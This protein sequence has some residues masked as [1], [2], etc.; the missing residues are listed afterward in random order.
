[1]HRIT[2][3]ALAGS[4]LLQ[5]P[6]AAAPQDDAHV[7]IFAS[8]LSGTWAFRGGDVHRGESEEVDDRYWTRVL[9]DA[10]SGRGAPTELDVAWYRTEFTWSRERREEVFLVLGRIAGAANLW[11]NGVRLDR[12][13]PESPW[14]AQRGMPHVYPVDG[15]A[16]RRGRN[17]IALRV[18]RD[19]GAATFGVVS[20]PLQVVAGAEASRLLRMRPGARNGFP[21]ANFAIAGQ[22]SPSG[23]VLSHVEVDPVMR[24]ESPWPLGWGELAV[25]E[26][27]RERELATQEFETRSMQRQWPST[28]YSFEDA[29]FPGLE[30]SGSTYAPVAFRDLWVS[31]LPVLLSDL[32]VTNRSGE[33]RVLFL[34]FRFH[35]AWDDGTGFSQQM[36]QDQSRLGFTMGVSPT[37]ALASDGDAVIDSPLP[38]LYR[39]TTR[40]SLRPGQSERVRMLLA[41]RHPNS[42]GHA[43]LPAPSTIVDVSYRN[44]SR[45]TTETE[46]VDRSL[47]T[48]GDGA[49]DRAFRWTTSAAV[50]A[51]RV[52]SDDEIAMLDGGLELVESG[53][54]AS[55]PHL[56]LFT[57]LERTMIERIAA[58]QGPNGR[59]PH[60]LGNPLAEEPVDST[61][62]AWFVLRAVR[63]RD[64]LGLERLPITLED[65]VHAAADYLAREILGDPERPSQPGLTLG[66][67]IERLAAMQACLSLYTKRRPP[68]AWRRAWSRLQAQLLTAPQEGGWWN[69][70][71]FGL[72]EARRDV[73]EG[74][75]GRGDVLLHEQSLLWAFSL[76]NRRAHLDACLAVF[77]A[78]ETPFGIPSRHI[79][80]GTT[81]EPTGPILP[82]MNY[83]DALGRI[84]NGY[85]E[86]G[87]RLLR[88]LVRADL[89]WR[90]ENLPHPALL[91]STGAAVGDGFDPRSGT[92]AAAFM[93]GVLGVSR[94]GEVLTMR[95]LAGLDEKITTLSL[96]LP[97]G[98]LTVRREQQGKLF[99]LRAATRSQQPILVHYGLRLAP[100]EAAPLLLPP[101]DSKDLSPVELDVQ[102]VH[103]DRFAIIPLS[104]QPAQAS[105]A[106]VQRR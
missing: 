17:L 41:Y 18:D 74:E 101:K 86:D 72:P 69:G 21:A 81:F 57:D 84:Q 99:A 77:K 80:H 61:A 35:K 87:I 33:D 67:R 62:T 14:T 34:R 12:L 30:L 37:L 82:Y 54:H 95:P 71:F 39:V 15:S 68:P 43:A 79:G 4:L 106:I 47:P 55:Y 16:L 48:S 97:L 22:V 91:P 25:Y 2:L 44:W 19:P 58:A 11:L 27:L 8:S 31:D 52:T 90:D 45:L 23:Q 50:R 20:G 1:M 5:C 29:R 65:P 66:S 85:A 104:L 88:S 103:D 105:E 3:I 7:A 9:P 36:V 24:G 53:F 51:T 76:L 10:R 63:L 78:V 40:L 96:V 13:V 94:R 102:R 100:D 98:G 93:G 46:R 64:W 60:A 49:F 73:G 38:N 89:G 83:L 28:A 70:S 42:I 59:I 56:Y 75:P 32:V 6:L 26:P 92:F